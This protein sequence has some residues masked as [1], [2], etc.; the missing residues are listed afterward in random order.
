MTNIPTLSAKEYLILD[1]LRAGA[2]RYGLD[3]V[4][5]SNGKL[6][7]GTIYVTLY[8]MEE[9]GYVSSRRENRPKDPGLPLRIYRITGTGERALRCA[10]AAAMAATQPLISGAPSHA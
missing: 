9:K 4:K 2:D 5:R 10:D 6:K 3:M 8:R 7:R 1:M